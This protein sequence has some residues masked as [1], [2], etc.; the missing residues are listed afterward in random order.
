MRLNPWLTVALLASLAVNAWLGSQL[1]SQNRANRTALTSAANLTLAPLQSLASVTWH[2]P[3]GSTQDFR[4]TILAETVKATFGT[5]YTNLFGTLFRGKP[6]LVIHQLDE[7]EGYLGDDYLP[8]AYSLAQN[9]GSLDGPDGRLLRQ[10]GSDLRRAG[11]PSPQ[12]QDMG[13]AG[14]QR[15]LSQLLN[16]EKAVRTQTL[17][18]PDGRVIRSTSLLPVRF[19]GY[20]VQIMYEEGVPGADPVASSVVNLAQIISRRSVTLPL[21]QAF[22]VLFRHTLVP[23]ATPKGRLY[24]QLVLFRPYPGHRDRQLA[25]VLLVGFTG[26]RSAAEQ[27]TLRL[28]HGWHLPGASS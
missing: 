23:G 20:D 3:K 18:L 7:L 21:G 12:V 8:A 11:F 19:R 27:E 17:T 15:R 5:F 22:L 25:Y 2:P 13:W 6:S 4:S 26:S 24:Y 1:L 28:A 10:F 9:T 14:F 16:I